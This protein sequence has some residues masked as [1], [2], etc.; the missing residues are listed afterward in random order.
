MTDQNYRKV[1]GVDWSEVSAMLRGRGYRVVQLG[2]NPVPIPGVLHIPTTIREMITLIARSDLFIGLDS[3]PSH[4]AASLNIPSILFFGAVNPAYRHFINLLK[5]NIIQ[6]PC[7]Y[8]GCFHET[9]DPGNLV[10]RIVGK[11]GKP[12]CS[13]HTTDRVM[14]CIYK[15]LDIR[16][17]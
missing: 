15:A 1:Y 9:S 13:V 8:A 16:E 14:L 10:C 3:G 5:I 17:N 2:K 6:E 7:V 12:P 4:I 11:K